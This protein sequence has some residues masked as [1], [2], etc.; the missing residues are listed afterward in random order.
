MISIDLPVQSRSHRSS[1]MDTMIRHEGEAPSVE[2]RM[3]RRH[4]RYRRMACVNT[5][6]C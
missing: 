6:H 1:S 2:L 4:D 3:Y 5:W